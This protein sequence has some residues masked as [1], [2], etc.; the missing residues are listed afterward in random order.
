MSGTQKKNLK[1]KEHNRASGPNVMKTSVIKYTIKYR[2]M[3][4][5]LST[6]FNV[7]VFNF[8]A[9]LRNKQVT[10]I[11]SKINSKTPSFI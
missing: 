8:L 7:I 5:H 3:H 10:L 9:N 1:G 2:P 4:K 6:A 11:V